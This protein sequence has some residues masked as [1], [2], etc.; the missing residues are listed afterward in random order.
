MPQQSHPDWDTH[1]FEPEWQELTAILS[2]IPTFQFIA[3][4]LADNSRLLKSM[5]PQ[6]ESSDLKQLLPELQDMDI[7]SMTPSDE[8]E[9]FLFKNG[10]WLSEHVRRKETVL[11]ELK[12]LHD[13][14]KAEKEKLDG[15]RESYK[16]AIRACIM[17][18]SIGSESSFEHL[19]N[20]KCKAIDEVFDQM[21]DRLT[22]YLA[23]KIRNEVAIDL[24]DISS[25]SEEDKATE[26]LQKWFIAH[27]ANPYPTEEEKTELS[28]QTGLNLKQINTWFGN[29]RGRYKRRILD[30]LAIKKRS[31]GSSQST[32]GLSSPDSVSDSGDS[33]DLAEDCGA[34]TN[35]PSMMPMRITR[36]RMAAKRPFHQIKVETTE[37][38]D[39]DYEPERKRVKK[40]L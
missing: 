8:F 33:D 16:Q 32:S 3:T 20:A 4:Q 2:K 26:P 27:L 18:F 21:T 7:D 35:S 29:H 15:F 12:K 14:Y 13:K 6:Y 23:A 37:E 17:P 11:D 5:E 30:Q 22:H 38:K 34:P 19:I 9:A 25:N 28:V 1:Q 36:Q 10:I 31:E 24:T 39:P 40:I